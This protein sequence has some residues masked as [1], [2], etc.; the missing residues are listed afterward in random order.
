MVSVGPFADSGAFGV[1]M[2]SSNKFEQMSDEELA[3]FQ[4]EQIEVTSDTFLLEQ[5]WKRRDRLAQHELDLRTARLHW[6]VW[7]TFILTLLGVTVS[8]IGYWPQLRVFFNRPNPTF[9]IPLYHHANKR[10]KEEKDL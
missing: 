9:M 4:N 6:I 7:A 10:E 2:S 3:Q 5:E 8:I 1:L